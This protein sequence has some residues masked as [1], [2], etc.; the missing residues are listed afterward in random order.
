VLAC[1]GEGGGCTGDAK[2]TIKVR[3]ELIARRDGRQTVSTRTLRATL[4][5]VPF[6]IAPGSSILVRSRL[7]PQNR[8]L[9]SRLGGG[10]L[11]VMLSGRGVLHRI[12]TLEPAHSR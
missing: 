6:A 8:T 1:D 5:N 2:A 9:L 12:V 10:P 4:A 7:S 3:E 11:D